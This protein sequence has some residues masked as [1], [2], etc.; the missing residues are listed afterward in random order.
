MILATTWKPPWNC[1]PGPS[2]KPRQQIEL[3]TKSLQYPLI[4]YL[5]ED[6]NDNDNDSDYA[7]GESEEIKP[8]KKK[9]GHYCTKGHAKIL[10]KTLKSYNEH[11]KESHPKL[12]RDH[13][14][15]KCEGNISCQVSKRGIQN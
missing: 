8:K 9:K 13:S 4:N 6:I 14:C 2:I 3:Q 10:F 12:A 7:N 5:V 1:V 11:I 15:D